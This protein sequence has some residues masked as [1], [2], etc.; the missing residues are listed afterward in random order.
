VAPA[1]PTLSGVGTA[2]MLLLLAALGLVYL[3][4]ARGQG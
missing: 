4:R 2:V 1:I 3:L